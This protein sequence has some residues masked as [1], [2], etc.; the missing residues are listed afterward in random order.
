[1]YVLPMFAV[2][3]IGIE[4]DPAA[5]VFNCGLFAMNLLAMF[6]VC[7]LAFKGDAATGECGHRH[8]ICHCEPP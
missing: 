8:T 4:L 5:R 3:F 2:A 6:N 1:M 7:R